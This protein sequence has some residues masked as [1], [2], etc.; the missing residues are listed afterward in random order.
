[1]LYSDLLCRILYI[2]ALLYFIVF[3]LHLAGLP[4]RL[5]DETQLLQLGPDTLPNLLNLCFG[6]PTAV[7]FA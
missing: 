6:K 3:Y 2:I 7:F 1:M 5:L 4:L